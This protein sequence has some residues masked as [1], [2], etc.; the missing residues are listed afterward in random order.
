MH[1][2]KGPNAQEGI[3]Q[4]YI[5]AGQNPA[6][7][8]I[9]PDGMVSDCVSRCR[10]WLA[11]WNAAIGLAESACPYIDCRLARSPLAATYSISQI[12]QMIEELSQ[13]VDS[14]F[15]IHSSSN[16]S[17]SCTW[18][19]RV[20][21]TR[22]IST[23]LFYSRLKRSLGTG[24]KRQTGLDRRCMYFILGNSILREVDRRNSR[25]RYLPSVIE[26]LWNRL[27]Q[28]T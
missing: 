19:V 13:Y 15:R 3:I 16:S 9:R 25:H 21:F 11:K 26:G 8:A 12:Y 4:A 10:V 17:I 5:Y 24:W 1:V 2:T 28:F 18:T 20:L 14:S 22:G 6:L 23:Q 7:L 27:P